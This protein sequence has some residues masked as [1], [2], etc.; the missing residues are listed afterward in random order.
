MSSKTI[1]FFSEVTESACD[2]KILRKILLKVARDFR[3][4]IEQINIIFTNDTALK[5]MKKQYFNEDRFTDVISFNLSE[6]KTLLD[7]EIYISVDRAKSQAQEYSVCLN[8]EIT[9][10][11]THG[12]LHLCGIMD[13]TDGEREKMRVLENH[14]LEKHF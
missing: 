5:K 13:S 8:H 1:H 3:F 7:G 4:K 2:E 14:Y 10:L 11:V 6:N 9:R 12:M